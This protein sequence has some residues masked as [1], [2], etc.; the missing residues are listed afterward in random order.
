M[1]A[2]A[3]TMYH[4][5]FSVIV[6][7]LLVLGFFPTVGVLPAY[8]DDQQGEG[9]AALSLSGTGETQNASA[10]AQGIKT[11][12]GNPATGLTIAGKAVSGTN[13]DIF[14]D[15]TA[16]FDASTGTL[17]LN[18]FAATGND[19]GGPMLSAQG[20]L[21]LV[22]HGNNALVGGTNA[23]GIFMQGSLV[24]TG[25]GNLAVSGGYAP[26]ND[27][28]FGI[29]VNGLLTFD[30]SFTGTVVATGGVASEESTGIFCSS[31]LTVRSGTVVATGGSAI[32]SM[33]VE[34]SSSYAMDGGVLVA[35][36]GNATSSSYGIRGYELGS[37][38]VSF[39]GGTAIVRAGLVDGGLGGQRAAFRFADP[40]LASVVKV[41][42]KVGYV[43]DTF[44]E[45]TTSH[46]GDYSLDTGVVVVPQ[47]STEAN[48][49]LG[50]PEQLAGDVH[51][52][53]TDGT[54]FGANGTQSEGSLD[55][56]G[57]NAV[58]VNL[59][60]STAN[61]A[62][63]AGVVINAGSYTLAGTGQLT[64]VGG[65]TAGSSS[66]SDGLYASC[67]LTVNGPELVCVG[68]A[69][70][71]KSAGYS[72]RGKVS[73][74]AGG[75][76]G[77]G[78]PS[79]RAYS[80][81][82]GINTWVD[83]SGTASILGVGG[84]VEAGNSSWGIYSGRADCADNASIMGVGGIALGQ[85]VGTYDTATAKGGTIIGVGG[86][87]KQVSAG[88]NSG[89][90]SY[91]GAKVVGL[92]GVVAE[93]DSN[94]SYGSWTEPYTSYAGDQVVAG[95][96]RPYFYYDSDSGRKFF[97]CDNGATG[98]AY[99]DYA[100]TQGETAV[101]FDTTQ[102]TI[103]TFKRVVISGIPAEV[104]TITTVDIGNVWTKLDPVN[105]IPFTTEVHDELDT[106][107]VNFN[108]KMELGDEAWI[109]DSVINKND[110]S[111]IPKVGKTYKYSVTVKAKNDWKFSESALGAG[112]PFKLIVGG[113]QV[114][115]SKQDV[116]IADDGSTATIT[117]NAAPVAPVAVKAISI[118]GAAV[119]GVANKTYTGKAQTQTPTV[120]VT[121]NGTTK[122]LKAGTDYTLSYKN[123]TNVG[124]ATVTITGKGD[125]K[126]S[127]KKTFT[128]NKAKVT[129]KRLA[130][131]N[132]L[133]TME[134][135]TKEYGKAT[136]A[137]VATNASFK[138][139]LAA[140]ALAGGF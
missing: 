99:T 70:S 82:H 8:A 42:A 69:S 1:G 4:K 81:S 134:Q 106:D 90:I 109:A 40:Q 138:D 137:I 84:N 14:G 35:Q 58:F 117:F 50:L 88:C 92:G 133:A 13:P 83:A 89:M 32:T 11:R 20:D 51:H 67:P 52:I 114:D 29:S 43:S 121:V 80:Y 5:A 16:A 116:D 25:D 57:H 129:W 102:G 119:G 97:A 118:A 38:Q 56:G 34:L 2:T 19:T 27:G 86:Y 108:D 6:S 124:T 95:R 61:S 59:Y 39:D 63:Q 136:T 120:K 7:L 85:S 79:A 107:G 123:N 3:E 110:G 127:I 33:G 76:V 77:A 48:N 49:F 44:Q 46:A 24:V 104:K 47:A 115:L 66:E 128:I 10:G 132:A 103:S 37:S 135:I 94:R 68:A 140:S 54:N 55:L 78:G 101:S 112:V 91:P 60:E 72:A 113:S 36:G 17:T 45:T 15:G 9:A 21:T 26:E 18:N 23:I 74:S 125:Y 41:A 71:T 31:G 100:G 96:T 122:T 130:G 62:I 28:S 73:V 93:G 30:P 105:K 22:L 12:N 65:V 126:D 131:A 64:S 75:L 111:G 139:T 87:S 98:L 53:G